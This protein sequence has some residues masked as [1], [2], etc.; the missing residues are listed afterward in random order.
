MAGY[1]IIL[2]HSFKKYQTTM[3]IIM[4]LP[5]RSSVRLGPGEALK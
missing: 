4:H 1:I 2:K 5:D 3:H